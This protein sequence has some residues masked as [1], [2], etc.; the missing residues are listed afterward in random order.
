MASVM[1]DKEYG[2]AH[3]IYYLCLF[4]DSVDEQEHTNTIRLFANPVT[5]KTSSTSAL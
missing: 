4:V 3:K 2:F 5:T 1:N